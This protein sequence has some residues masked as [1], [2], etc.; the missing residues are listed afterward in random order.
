MD[1]RVEMTMQRLKCDR[2]KALEYIRNE[3]DHRVKFARFIYAQDFRNAMLYDL[4]VNM[5]HMTLEAACRVIENLMQ[6]PDFQATPESRA[7]VDRLYLATSIE[8][9]LVTDTRTASLE[10]NVKIDKENR[11]RLIGPYLDDPEL[12]T[13]TQITTSLPYVDTFEYIPGYQ[14]MIEI[15]SQ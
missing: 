8:E 6:E 7:E 4:T 12:D 11:I 1:M 13:V 9:A 5:E 2:E 10:I 15:D 14:S 3:D